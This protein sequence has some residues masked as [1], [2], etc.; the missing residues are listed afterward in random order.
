MVVQSR[1][2]LDNNAGLFFIAQVEILA[3]SYCLFMDD[4][5]P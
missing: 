3:L 4:V 5:R 2:N 1:T